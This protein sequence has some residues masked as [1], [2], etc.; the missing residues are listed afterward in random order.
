MKRFYTLATSVAVVLSASANMPGLQTQVK[1]VSKD[2][3]AVSTVKADCTRSLEN[4]NHG[5]FFKAPSVI[6]DY[7]GDYEWSRT[8]LLNSEPATE[9][10]IEVTDEATGAAVISGFVFGWTLNA[11]IDLEAKT[12]TIP[13]MQKLDA[14]DDE[15]DILFYLSEVTADGEI[16]GVSEATASVGAIDGG[17]ITFPALD[18][19]TLGVPG[20]GYYTL[21]YLNALTL[22]EGKD[23][24]EGWS[25]LGEGKWYDPFYMMFDSN[26]NAT[27]VLAHNV[28]IQESESM[29][30]Y[31]RLYPYAQEDNAFNL[32]YGLGVDKKCE[33]LLNATDPEKIYIDGDW[34]PFP[35]MIGWWYSHVCEEN[36]WDDN[37]FPTF[38]SETGEITFSRGSILMCQKAD[39]SSNIYYAFGTG[40]EFKIVL[41]SKEGSAVEGVNTANEAPVFYNLQG[42]A[43]DNPTKGQLV[44]KIQDG[45]SVKMI[46]K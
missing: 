35:S 17:T 32:A 28:T 27:E 16:G 21:T 8:S 44:I 7:T 30:G 46:A 19:W 4:K 9:L 6:A 39:F 15:K 26:G 1:T 36:Y 25:T 38:D 45:K 3:Q 11:T 18:I 13:T 33:I 2:F 12:I 10:S 14:Y 37:K 40:Y 24:N 20:L 43:I 22:N 23:P 31:Y 41:P 5:V 34:S 29:P 42:A